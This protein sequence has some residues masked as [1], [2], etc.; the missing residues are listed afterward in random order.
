MSSLDQLADLARL[1]YVML[2]DKIDSAE[3]QRNAAKREYEQRIV[4]LTRQNQSLATEYQNT[5]TQLEGISQKLKD[6]GA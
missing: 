2:Q 5:Q 3:D 1:N 4:M 6:Q